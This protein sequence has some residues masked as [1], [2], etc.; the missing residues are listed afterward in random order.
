MAIGLFD[1]PLISEVSFAPS[2]TAYSIGDSI[3]GALSFDVSKSANGAGFLM[4]VLAADN[5]GIGAAGAL[6][7]F[8]QDLATPIADNAAF[9]IAFAD[10]ANL[11]TVVTLDAY[12]TTSTFKHSLT[13]PDEVPMLHWTKNTIT[14]YWVASGAPDWA[15]SKLAYVQLKMLTQ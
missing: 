1:R 9:A 13:R 2:A 12:T 14:G 10:Y 11:L 5:E 7:L 6:W 8:N 4:G 15:A 3:G